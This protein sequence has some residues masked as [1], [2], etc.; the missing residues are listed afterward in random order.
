MWHEL[1]PVD[2]A[3]TMC[4]AQGDLFLAELRA[5]PELRDRLR[6]QRSTTT[7]RLVA[8]RSCAW[9]WTV[10]TTDDA[11]AAA[12]VIA[13]RAAAAEAERL[14]GDVG[15]HRDRRKNDRPVLDT[16]VPFAVTTPASAAPSPVLWPR[17]C[18]RP[19]P[20]T[21]LLPRTRDRV[22]AHSARDG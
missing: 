8:C 20:R 21:A 12:A 11:A 18:E 9:R 4:G 6:G 17:T 10:R 22:L 16:L 7:A 2:G 14:R 15:A 3:C 13:S 1:G 5:R 19:R